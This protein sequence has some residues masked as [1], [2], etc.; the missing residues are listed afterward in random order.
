MEDVVRFLTNL[1]ISSFNSVLLVALF[2]L[3]RA[4]VV[5]IDEKVTQLWEWH[6]V[7]KGKED[8][9]RKRLEE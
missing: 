5:A 6:L 7:Q 2:F 4:K 9:A 1:G 8:A 3:I